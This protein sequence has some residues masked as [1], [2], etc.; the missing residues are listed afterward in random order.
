M[1]RKTGV[2]AAV[3]IGVAVMALAQTEDDFTVILTEDGAGAVI[4]GYSGS[5]SE[6]RIPATIQGFPVRE[7]RGGLYTQRGWTSVIIPEGVTTIG[8]YAFQGGGFTSVTLPSTLKTIGYGAFQNCRVL[9]SIVIPEGV[10]TLEARAFYGCSKLTS[11]TLPSTLKTIRSITDSESSGAF[12]NCTVLESIIIPEGVTAIDVGTF[13][14]CGKLTSV[15]LPSTI[16]IIGSQ[17]FDGCSAL[18][19]VIIPDLVTSIN[20]HWSSFSGCTKLNL[21]S[22]A[23]LKRTGYTDSF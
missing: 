23:A 22:Q 5:T 9:E 1:L 16:K 10:T 20:I 2:L 12:Q 4:T 13:R 18:T 11:V 14:G 6:V 17:A 3:L 8:A 19:T 7:I 21:A 15:T